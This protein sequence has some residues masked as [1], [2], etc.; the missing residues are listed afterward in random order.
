MK[1]NSTIRGVTLMVL[2]SVAF[3]AMSA[4]IKFIPD[5]DSY[6]TTL[7][8]SMIGVAD[9][10]EQIVSTGADGLSVETTMK[11][12]VNDRGDISSKIG[13]RISLFG[14][15]DPVGILQNGSDARLQAEIRRQAQAARTAR[16]FIMCTGSPITPATPLARV[17]LFI[18]LAQR[19]KG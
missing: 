15:I 12:Y 2:A 6:K 17:R 3:C 1:L 7:F 16:G 5:I 14:N 18:D 19:S 9:R 8:R 11:N 10:L 4:L 13:R